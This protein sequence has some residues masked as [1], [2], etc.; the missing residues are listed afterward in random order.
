MTYKIKLF[1]PSSDNS[2][3]KNVV[4]TIKSGFWA[5]GAGTGNVKKFEEAFMKFTKAKECVA[6]DSGTAALHLA[7][8]ISQIKDKEVLVPSMTF[9]STVNA[10][11]YNGGKPIFVDID[12]KTLCIDV[13]DLKKKISKKTRVILPV[14]FGGFPIEFEKIQKIANQNSLIIVEDAA[15]ACGTT[16]KG[17]QVGSLGDLTCFSFHPV[18]NLAMPKGGAITINSRDSKIIKNKLNSLRWCGIS[19]RNG[20]FYDI[21]ELGYNY[22]MDEIS[23]SIGIEQLKKT[24]KLNKKRLKI[25][26]LYSKKINIEQKM[27]FTE[28][29]SYHLYWILVNNRTDFLKKI[30]AKGIEVGIHYAPIHKTKFYNSKQILVNTE[31]VAKQIVTLPIHPNLNDDDIEYI[32][33]NVN[34]FN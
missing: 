19:N 20:P 29:S 27:S 14:Y 30:N 6:V 24:K 5:S 25:A 26:K 33:K 13:E 34:L 18:K 9:A 2:E 10:I 15:H 11:L 7:L 3:I 8:N 16:Y 1:S 4:K 17:K 22:Y 12:P 31:R 21:S 28:E 32:I 23:A